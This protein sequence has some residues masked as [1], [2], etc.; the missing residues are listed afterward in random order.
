MGLMLYPRT[1]T[2]LRTN[3]AQCRVTL[4]PNDVT[5]K[6][7]R[8][9]PKPPLIFNQAT[10]ANSTWSSLHGQAKMSTRVLNGEFCITV[11]PLTMTV[12]IL[13]QLA[14]CL[15]MESTA[16]IVTSVLPGPPQSN[17]E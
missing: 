13:T 15:M 12:G 4:V 10:Q 14:I 7:N 3:R 1:V 6:P 5:S 9:Q 2:H 17:L 8:H 16:L 11:C